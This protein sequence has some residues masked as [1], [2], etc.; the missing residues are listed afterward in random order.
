VDNIL[1]A[2]DRGDGAREWAN[3]LNYRPQEGPMRLSGAILVPG[4]VTAL[5]VFGR[6][7]APLTD[8]KFPSTLVNVSNVVFGPWNYPMLGAVTGDLQ[9]P[10]TLWFLEPS[11]EPPAIPLAAL[12]ALPGATIEIGMPR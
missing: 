10:W 1:R 8:I 9:H 7:G 11:I 6:D 2:L 12:T 3:R 5:P 4:A